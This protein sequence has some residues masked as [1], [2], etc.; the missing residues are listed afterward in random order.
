[1]NGTVKLAIPSVTSSSAQVAT[2]SLLFPRTVVLIVQDNDESLESAK[3][4]E[5]H[6][7][8]FGWTITLHLTEGNNDS[9]SKATPA[10]REYFSSVRWILEKV[11]TSLLALERIIC[12][13]PAFSGPA[14][15]KITSPLSLAV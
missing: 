3:D 13:A 12:F 9:L 15:G 5:L 7:N 4:F 14:N 10:V 2:T 8:N 11:A 6:K 1:M